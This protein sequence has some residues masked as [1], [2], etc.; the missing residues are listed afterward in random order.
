[1]DDAQREYDE[2]RKDLVAIRK[3]R[4]RHIG[5]PFSKIIEDQHSAAL[6]RVR[7]ARAALKGKTIG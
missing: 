4:R 3:E 7:Q 5:R 1:M 2:A 6:T